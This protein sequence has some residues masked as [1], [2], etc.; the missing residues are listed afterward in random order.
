MVWT[1]QRTDTFLETFAQAI[2]AND[3]SLNN[4]LSIVVLKR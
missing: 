4:N 3:T 2:Y 1:I